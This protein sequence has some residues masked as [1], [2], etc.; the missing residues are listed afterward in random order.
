[1]GGIISAWNIRVVGEC[2]NSWRAVVMSREDMQ[3]NSSTCGS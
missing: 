2:F 1:M 3:G